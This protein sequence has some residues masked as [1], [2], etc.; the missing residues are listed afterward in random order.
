MKTWAKVAIGC[1]AVLLILCIVLAVVFFF[2]GAWLKSKLGGFFGGAYE[3]GKNVAA[4]QKLEQ[5]YPFQEPADGA[6]SEGRLQAYLAA[7]SK[8]KGAVE[9]LREDLQQMNNGGSGN[10]QDANRAMA[11][12]G[13]LTQ[14]VREGLEQAKMSPAEFKWLGETAYPALEEAPSGTTGGEIQGQAGL[15]AMANA[16]LEPLQAQLNDP[17]LTAEQK[18]ALQEQIDAIKAT[19]APESGGEL[20]PNAALVQKYRQQLEENDV[21]E[22]VTLVSGIRGGSGG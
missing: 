12:M 2:A 21:R 11:A 4:I 15:E 14:A 19:M 13:T 3:T 20:S 5:Q 1:L 22:F 16:S 10:A 6:I 17:S 9:P 18:Q 8:I 7:C